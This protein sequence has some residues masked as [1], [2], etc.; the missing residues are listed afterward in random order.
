MKTL[1]IQNKKAIAHK[2]S[3]S[4]QNLGDYIYW[5]TRQNDNKPIPV[6]SFTN[7]SVRYVFLQ[8]WWWQ[9]HLAH[10]DQKLY[11][12]EVERWVHSVRDSI[13]KLVQYETIRFST[14]QS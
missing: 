3:S 5:V 11:P 4:E 8:R 10:H 12:I 9:R 2:S 13:E 7:L 14:G 1:E 6:P